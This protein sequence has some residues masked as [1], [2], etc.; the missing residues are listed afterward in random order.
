MMCSFASACAFSSVSAT[1]VPTQNA[2]CSGA[3]SY[4]NSF[5]ARR[6]MS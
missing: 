4:P 2:S 3:G 1:Y 5:A 6:Y